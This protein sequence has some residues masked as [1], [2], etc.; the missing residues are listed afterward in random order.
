[1][2]AKIYS[3]DIPRSAKV[4]YYQ[5]DIPKEQI[6]DVSSV[7]VDTET[8]GLNLF[9]DRLCLVQ[10][11]FGDSHCYLVR[12]IKGQKYPNL[13]KLMQNKKVKKIFHYGR[14]DIAMLYKHFDILCENVFCTKIASKLARTNTERHG[15]PNLCKELLGVDIP[16]EQ[17]SS[18]WGSIDL[19][20]AQ[21]NYAA[22]DVLYLHRLSEILEE[23][24]VRENRMIIAEKCFN[25]LPTRAQL[26]CMG[27]EYDI[28]D[29]S[30]C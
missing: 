22:M 5:G 11:C 24:M 29:W 28:F 12:V 10:L 25:F 23:R 4:V 3:A 2:D 8:T 9:R 26:D 27:W 14:F 21:K 15:L 6:P 18:D 16:K 20:D 17:Q 13:C 1:M 7:A 19:T 30:K